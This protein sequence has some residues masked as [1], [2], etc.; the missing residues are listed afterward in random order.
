MKQ[1]HMFDVAFT[2]ESTNNAEDVTNE[3]ILKAL[4]KRWASLRHEFKD[5]LDKPYG[6]AFGY[7]DSYDVREEVSK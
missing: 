2:V 4:A 3:E 5:H 6:E 7:S 1:N